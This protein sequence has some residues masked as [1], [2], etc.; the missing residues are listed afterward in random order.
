MTDGPASKSSATSSTVRQISP[1]S[2]FRTAIGEAVADG[3]GVDEL[4]LRLTL[5]DATRVLRDPET[6]SDDIRFEGGV[7]RFLGVRV[8]Q[9][10]IE[11]SVLER[12][13][14]KDAG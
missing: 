1:T 3:A 11:A 5:R 14:P 6:L 4:V 2:R 7:M 9:G 10:G 13:G 12:A 8:L